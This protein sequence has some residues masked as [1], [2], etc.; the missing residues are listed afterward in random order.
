MEAWIPL[1]L[2]RVLFTIDTISSEPANSD[3]TPVPTGEIGERRAEEGKRGEGRRRKESEGGTEGRKRQKEEGG[4]ERRGEEEKE[5]RK[6]SKMRE[7]EEEER[8]SGK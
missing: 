3:S 7:G 6:G 4:E 2:S 1:Y 5:K 8:R